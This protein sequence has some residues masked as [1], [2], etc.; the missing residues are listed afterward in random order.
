[1]RE[2]EKLHKKKKYKDNIKKTYIVSRSFSQF[3]KGRK[4]ANKGKGRKNKYVDPRMKKDTRSKLKALKNPN[5][6]KKHK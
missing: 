1:M 2:I 6:K 3:N 4:G 5:K